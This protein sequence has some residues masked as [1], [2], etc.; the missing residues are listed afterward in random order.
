MLS[1]KYSTV[2]GDVL[3]SAGYITLI[4][5][6][7]QRYRSRMLQKWTKSLTDEGFQCSKEFIF[8]EL[9]GDSYQIRKWHVNELPLDHVSVNNALVIEKTT[10]FCLLIDP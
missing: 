5:G 6:F 1:A 7:N 8:T 9:F 4:G 10:R 3:L 2:T